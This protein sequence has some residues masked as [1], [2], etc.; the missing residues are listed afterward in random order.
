MSW[1]VLATFDNA[2]AAEMAKNALEQQGI[3]VR[4]MDDE[5][6]DNAWSRNSALGGI[7]LCVDSQDLGRAEL[8]LDHKTAALETDAE[9]EAAVAERP[10]IAAQLSGPVEPFDDP[11]PDRLVQRAFVTAVLGLLFLPARFAGAS[12]SIVAFDAPA[13]AWLCIPFQLYSLYLLVK[14]RWSK[15]PVR[16]SNRWKIWTA[17]LVNVPLWVV[18]IVPAMILLN[19]F[20]NDPYAPTWKNTRFAG[21][22]DHT[23]T[24]D[25]AEHYG[26]DLSEKETPT[27][28]L[29]IR[30]F[31]TSYR[32]R[33][34]GVSIESLPAEFKPDD[35]DDALRTYIDRE[36]KG[37]GIRIQS[38]EA[39]QFGRYPA[40]EITSTYSDAK[41]GLP[42]FRR[43]RIA[44]VDRHFVHLFADLPDEAREG[45]DVERFFRSAK[46]D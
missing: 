28:P 1:E 13:L 34:F 36:V 46:I 40:R 16:S 44:L 6:I 17:L 22:D 27:G 25:F 11:E 15:I 33:E 12:E 10:D 43:T 38:N 2:I 45:R 42:R 31:F 21:F 23:M 19:R 3:A 37:P 39:I 35:A 14:I 29:K 18:V 9:I 7:K 8:L 5:T 41:S 20:G 4:I 24:I 26:Y 32:G 30:S